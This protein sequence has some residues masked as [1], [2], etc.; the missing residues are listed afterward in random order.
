[1]Y[2]NLPC[3]GNN[4][5]GEEMSGSFDILIVGIGGQG[6]ILASNILGEACLAEGRHV[7]GAETHGMAQRGGSVESHIRIDGSF[8]PLIPPGEADLLISFDI[9]EALRYS[10]YLKKGGKMIVNNHLVLPTSVFTQNLPAPSQDEVIIALKEHNLCLLDAD[11]I[12]EEA[13]SILSQNVV[14]LGAASLTIPLKPESLVDAVKHLVPKKT[15]DINVK[16]F[17]LGRVYGGKC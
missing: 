10:H 9:L 17:E 7:K 12:A 16:A 15:V 2:P 8:G 11:K 14:M 1:M 6:T 5:G 4:A 13:G 3:R